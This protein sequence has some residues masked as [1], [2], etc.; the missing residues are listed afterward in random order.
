[1]KSERKKSSIKNMITAVGSNIIT[2]IVGLVAQAIFIKI[3]GS[4]YLG[5]NGLFSNVIS[6]L[7]IVELGMGSAIIYN[8][9]KPIAENDHEKIKSLMH[10]YKKSYLIITLIISIIGI[11]IIPFIKYI[12]DIESVTVDVNVYLVYILFLLETIC[13]YILSYKRS[14]LY[15]D[16]K[17]YIT[18]IIHMGYTIIVN[19]MQLSFLYFTHDYYLYLIIKVIMRLV[20]NIVISSYVNRRYSYLLD[21]NVTKLDSKTEKDIF[22]KIKALFFHKIGGF[23]VSG[24]DNIIISKYLG[25][26]T[27]GL[28]SN[29]Y[30]IINAVQT[31]INHIIQATRA[32]VGNLLVTESKKKQFDIFN[33]IRFVNFWISCFSSI[34][35]FVIMDSFIT[36]WIGYKFVLPTKVLL[37]LVINFFIVSSRSTYS[38]FKEAAGIFYED[39]FVPIIE[40]LL[41][42]VLSIIFVKK[43]GLMGVF[44]GTVASGLAL[45]CYSYPKY[46][47]KNLFGRSYYDYIKETIYY[48]I[49]FVLIAGFSYSLAIL[50]SFENVYLQFISNVLIALIVPNVIM[51]LLFSKD[52]NFKYFINM[53]KGFKK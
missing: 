7:G 26:V 34:C 14:M 32:S 49:V 16:Q 11:M 19:T 44:M 22:Q 8:M 30:M 12:V 23:I 5:L 29:Y 38:A 50:I 20:E 24:T 45:W 15:A 17:E 6:M 48:L 27:V 31:V 18:N 3:L 13:S 21:N 25:L 42:I 51:L 1:M 33:K 52:E 2:I 4:E 39:R 36:I 47:Y 40:S 10:F 43:F 37:V 9:Y 46:V 28:Y 35:I 41:N 53:L